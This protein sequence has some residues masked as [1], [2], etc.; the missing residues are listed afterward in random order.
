[1]A[2]FRQKFIKHSG[3]EHHAVVPFQQVLLTNFINEKMGALRSYATGGRGD[4]YR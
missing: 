4:L 3:A 1:M 2:Y